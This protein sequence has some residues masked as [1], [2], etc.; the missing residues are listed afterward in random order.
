M[1]EAPENGKELSNSARANGMTEYHVTINESWCSF[2]S[3]TDSALLPS[4]DICVHASR[5]ELITM[6][7]IY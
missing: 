6:Y 1:E 7:R 5:Q 3:R 2:D 4:S